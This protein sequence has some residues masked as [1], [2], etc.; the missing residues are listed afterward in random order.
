MC[1]E[2]K[3]VW[4]SVCIVFIAKAVVLKKIIHHSALSTN[5]GNI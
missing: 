5:I 4:P 2:G 1:E 3:N